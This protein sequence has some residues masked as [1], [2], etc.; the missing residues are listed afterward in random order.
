[1]EPLGKGLIRLGFSARGVI[2]YS[3]PVPEIVVGAA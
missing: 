1:V 3:G 2:G